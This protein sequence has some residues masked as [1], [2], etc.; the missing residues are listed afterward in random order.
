[1]SSIAEPAR[2]AATSD[3]LA[4]VAERFARAWASPDVDR[5]AELL[6]PDVLLLQPVTRPIRGREAARAEFARLLAWLPDLCG[7][8][9][10][11]AIDGDTLLLAWRLRFGLGGRPYELRIVDRIVVADGLIREREAYY[12]SLGLMIALLGRPGAWLG[13]WRYRGYLPGAR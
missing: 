9:D 4:S 6:H 10:R 11:T 2:P 1:M 13:Y 5:F 7:T 3:E 8:V 12:D